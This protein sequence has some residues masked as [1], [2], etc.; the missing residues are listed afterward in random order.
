MIDELRGQLANFLISYGHYVRECGMLRQ[1]LD[2]AFWN[3]KLLSLIE[4]N[5]PQLAKEMGYVKL[6]EDQTFPVLFPEELDDAYCRGWEQTAKD[7]LK[8]GWRKVVQE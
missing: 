5:F 4:S 3:S 7:M 2:Y 8:A 1:E 6:A